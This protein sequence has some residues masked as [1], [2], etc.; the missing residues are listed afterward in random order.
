MF[1][2]LGHKVIHLAYNINCYRNI[3]VQFT[4]IISDGREQ[5]AKRNTWKC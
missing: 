2:L 5:L 4:D 3:I 1:N